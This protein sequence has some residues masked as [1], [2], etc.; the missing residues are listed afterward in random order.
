MATTTN[1]IRSAII[2][3]NMSQK[4]KKLVADWRLHVSIFVSMSCLLFLLLLMVMVERYNPYGRMTIRI[5]FFSLLFI[6]IPVGIHIKSFDNRDIILL[7][8]GS[9]QRVQK[10][11]P[12]TRF[13]YN[14]TNIFAN[15]L[16]EIWNKKKRHWLLSW[17]RVYVR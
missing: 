4:L 13:Y 16:C 14:G 1:G 7:L 9:L 11:N 6:N 12:T 17:L 2:C 10:K 8:S 5:P 3:T 15:L